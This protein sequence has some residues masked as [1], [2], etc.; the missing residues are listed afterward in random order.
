MRNQRPVRENGIAGAER[1]IKAFAFAGERVKGGAVLVPGLSE[2]GPGMGSRG[3][4]EEPP[5][6]G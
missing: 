4:R 5:L 3:G 6:A 1:P 2:D